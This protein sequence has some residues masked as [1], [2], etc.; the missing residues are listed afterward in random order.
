MFKVQSS[1][2]RAGE[3]G[4]EQLPRILD[5]IKK[6]TDLV[7][8]ELL[9]GGAAELLLHFLVPQYQPGQLSAGR[10]AQHQKNGHTRTVVQSISS[11]I[12][13][14]SIGFVWFR[15]E[16]SIQCDVRAGLAQALGYGSLAP[17]SF[18]FTE[19]IRRLL[20]SLGQAPQV[21]ILYD[22]GFMDKSCHYQFV[23]VN[24][25]SQEIQLRMPSRNQRTRYNG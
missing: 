8:I 18:P 15:F 13:D 16:I 3:G 5:D 25:Y 19:R 1:L 12:V 11:T 7:A 10:M 9:N 14:V 6:S 21:G 17:S 4:T 20:H 2:E 22:A 23:N 24:M